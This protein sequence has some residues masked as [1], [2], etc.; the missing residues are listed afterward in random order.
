MRFSKRTAPFRVRFKCNGI[1]VLICRKNAVSNT[2]MKSNFDDGG[3]QGMLRLCH[4]DEL[5]Y[6]LHH[7][8]V[9]SK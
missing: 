4:D 5:R 6:E 7:Q 8:S 1:G 3:I 9:V 2:I